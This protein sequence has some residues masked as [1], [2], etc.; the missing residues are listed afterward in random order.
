[1][2][3]KIIEQNL[4][5]ALLDEG[6]LVKELFEYELEE[7]VEEYLQSKQADKDKYFFAITE[8]TDDVAMLLIDENN[9]VHVNED[10]RVLLKKLWSHE[11]KN[12]ITK[13]IP[14]IAEQLHEGYLFAAGV[15]TVGG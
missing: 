5:K 11:Y 2:N 9:I 6:P 15:K 4:K 7:H 8:H 12:N 1:M 10:A 14:L 3:K 13:L